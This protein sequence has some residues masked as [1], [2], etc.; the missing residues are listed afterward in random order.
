MVQ[1]H[2][3]PNQLI[4]VLEPLSFPEIIN[5]IENLVVHGVG[6]RFLSVELLNFQIEV[7]REEEVEVSYPGS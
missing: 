1:L 5:E 4:Q 7:V 3:T 2:F 6:A